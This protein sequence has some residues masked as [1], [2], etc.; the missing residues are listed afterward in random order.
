ML[1]AVSCSSTHHAILRHGARSF[2]LAYGEDGDE[3]FDQVMG[4]SPLVHKYS[5]YLHFRN[6]YSLFMYV[7]DELIQRQCMNHDSK[8]GRCSTARTLGSWV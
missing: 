5:W 8:R 2:F 6:S 3:G 4:S 1:S 7:R